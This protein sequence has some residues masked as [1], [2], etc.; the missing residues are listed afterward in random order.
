MS[1]MYIHNNKKGIEH[2]E[3]AQE[4][5]KKKKDSLEFNLKIPMKF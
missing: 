3:K 5:L 2:Y 1:Y 4:A